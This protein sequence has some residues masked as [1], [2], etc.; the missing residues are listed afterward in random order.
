MPINKT[1]LAKKLDFLNENLAKIE[2]MDFAEDEFVGQ[3][4]IHDLLTFRLQQSVETCIDVAVHVIAELNLPRK[5]TAKDA[6]LL[7][8]EQNI[9]SRDLSLRMGRAADF[10]N[11]VVHGYNDFDFRLLFR[12]YHDDVN[13]LRIFGSQILDFLEK[14]K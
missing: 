10:R 3:A 7:L 13:D 14:N 12:D 5:E 6:F 2:N 1:I 4:D 8:G 11:R 9:I